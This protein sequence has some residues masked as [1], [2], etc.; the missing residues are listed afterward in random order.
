MDNTHIIHEIVKCIKLHPYI[1][2]M[3]DGQKYVFKYVLCA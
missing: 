3:C 2:S 1:Y